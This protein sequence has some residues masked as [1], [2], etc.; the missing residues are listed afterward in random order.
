MP[1][2]R[3]MRTDRRESERC[4]IKEL[5]KSSRRRPN[6]TLVK[7]P[8]PKGCVVHLDRVGFSCDQAPIHNRLTALGFERIYDHFVQQKGHKLKLYSRV[9]RYYHPALHSQIEIAYE[10]LRPWI[11]FSRVVIVANDRRGIRRQEVDAILPALASPRLIL[12]EIAVDF[13][14][15]SGVTRRFVLS[16]GRFGKSQVR[17]SSRYPENLWF[18]SR[19]SAKFVRGYPKPEVADFRVEVELHGAFLRKYEIKTIAEFHKLPRILFPL[20]I[21]FVR[22]DEESFDRFASK[23]LRFADTIR[24]VVTTNS[25]SLGHSLRVLR[26]EFGLQ[27]LQRHLTPMPINEEVL[28]ALQVWAQK[29]RRGGG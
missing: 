4:L 22:I 14:A 9:C 15:T 3:K 5:E 19:R 10:P 29:W 18:G 2:C 12:A 23:H 25:R 11:P 21:F 7:P 13:V 16:H 6:P 17:T 26:A 28:R 20:H 8:V 24:R 27:N 1:T